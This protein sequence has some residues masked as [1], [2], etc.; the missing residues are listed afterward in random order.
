MEEKKSAIDAAAQT[1]LFTSPSAVAD[2][3]KMPRNTPVQGNWRD[4]KPIQ[5]NA[6]TLAL[7]ATVYWK[8]GFSWKFSKELQRSVESVV[9]GLLPLEK[10]RLNHLPNF[11]EK[12]ISKSI[13]LL[14]KEG[15][16]GEV[17]KPQ[18]TPLNT[19]QI[20]DTEFIKAE[21]IKDT[22]RFY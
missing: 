20:Q 14:A 3:E 5:T 6:A 18:F 13:P 4:F 11:K 17:I 19:L 8:V 2:K 7:S 9:N 22:L 21:V 15:D 16:A 10:V 12:C 1:S